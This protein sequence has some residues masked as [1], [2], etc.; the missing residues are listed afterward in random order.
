MRWLHRKNGQ[1]LNTSIYSYNLSLVTP[2][3]VYGVLIWYED[4]QQY[5]LE[6]MQAIFIKFIVFPRKR[7]K[8]FSSYCLTDKEL[9]KVKPLADLNFV[10]NMGLNVVL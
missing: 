4:Y 8:C 7:E 2:I 6:F 9:H 3:F 10:K 1:K 5:R